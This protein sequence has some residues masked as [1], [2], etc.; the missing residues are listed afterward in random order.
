MSVKNQKKLNAV[1]PARATS[2]G[3]PGKNHKIFHGKPL[4]QYSI[5]AA[6]Q[7]S[8]IDKVIV[9]TDCD[10]IKELVRALSKEQIAL[11]DRP[12]EFAKD[13][14]SMAAVVKDLRDAMYINGD[15]YFCLLQPTS[16]LRNSQH[17][18]KC[19]GAFLKNG[20]AR[21]SI[22][23]YPSPISP[24][25]MLKLEGGFLAPFKNKEDLA[26]PRQSLRSTYA[27]NG[28]IY[29]GSANN[30]IQENSF[31]HEPCLP[32]EMSEKDSVDVDSEIDWMTAE[33]LMKQ[34]R[35]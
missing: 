14:S 31:F 32:F 13:A 22:S 12:S 9:T 26:A 33:F 30:V 2:R 18:D 7:A 1:I 5:E 16:P 17:I 20:K 23:V 25:K 19:L 21:S 3:M 4:I 35:A 8:L 11:R 34:Q 10:H 15:E 27:Q 28:A 24:F 6:L 29:V